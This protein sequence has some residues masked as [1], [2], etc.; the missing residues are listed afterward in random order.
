MTDG[1]SP[2]HPPLDPKGPRRHGGVRAIVTGQVGLDKKPFLQQV[3]DLAAAN[4][5]E[6]KLFNVGER[7]CAEALSGPTADEQAIGRPS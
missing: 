3:V 7:M 1:R 4:G 6:V 5:R 2:I